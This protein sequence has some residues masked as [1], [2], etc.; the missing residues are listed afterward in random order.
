[1]IANKD[2]ALI[3]A[4]KNRCKCNG[5]SSSEGESS[6]DL[7]SMSIDELNNLMY[8]A[9]VKAQIKTGERILEEDENDPYYTSALPVL[10][11]APENIS[12]ITTEGTI[13][14][15]THN[16]NPPLYTILSPV[17]GEE[18]ITFII[19]NTNGGIQ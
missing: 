4:I 7:N 16:D 11:N 3:K 6:M 15:V 10:R 17:Y 12:D 19:L 2:Y 14:K 13:R 1:M 5:S 9:A 18:L 8:Q